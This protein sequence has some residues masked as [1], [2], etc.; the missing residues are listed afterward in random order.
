MA[1]SYVSKPENVLENNR[2]RVQGVVFLLSG[3]PKKLVFP[4]QQLRH[5]AILACS[6][7]IPITL[8]NLVNFTGFKKSNLVIV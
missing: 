3:F 1:E 5:T 4:R 7:F 8:I 6:R 2:K